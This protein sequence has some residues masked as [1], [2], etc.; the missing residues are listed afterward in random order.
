MI[1]RFQCSTI[2]N[3]TFLPKNKTIIRLACTFS[4]TIIKYRGNHN[5]T[6]K[7]RAIISRNTRESRSSK[8]Q[9]FREISRE[10]G[11]G[12][13]TVS[14]QFKSYDYCTIF[15][16]SSRET[17]ERARRKTTPVLWITIPRFTYQ[18]RTIS[19]CD[20]FLSIAYDDCTLIVRLLYDSCDYFTRM[21]YY[22]TIIVRFLLEFVESYDYGQIA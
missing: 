2:Q 18:I 3:H 4:W 1:V 9:E 21:I 12:Q 11:V 17:T 5:Q 22:R 6:G 16:R 8:T 10:G 7:K 19:R 15:A 13:V 20:S 14:V